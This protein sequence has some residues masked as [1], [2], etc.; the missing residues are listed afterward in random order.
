MYCKIPNSSISLLCHS[1]S[2]SLSL[3]ETSIRTP[4]T[5]ITHPFSTRT[6]IFHTRALF[7]YSCTHLNCTYALSR[8]PIGPHI[9]LIAFTLFTSAMCVP[10]PLIPRIQE[11]REIGEKQS[12]QRGQGQVK[13]EEKEAAIMKSV[14]HFIITKN[15]PARAGTDVAKQS[16]SRSQ[17]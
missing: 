11:R 3:S 12:W 16:T 13:M 4:H 7:G 8:S 17:Q 14:S 2:L 5:F 1:S 15:R 10:S 9:V 6:L